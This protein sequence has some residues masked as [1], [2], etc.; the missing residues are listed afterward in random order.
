MAVEAP[1]FFILGGPGSGKGTN[2]D[3]LVRDFGMTHFSAGDLLR[4]EA[5][6][7]TPLGAK[8]TKILADGQI[9]PSEVTVELLKNAITSAKDAKGFLIDGFPRKFDQ[10]Q[11]F[12]EGIAKARRVLYFDCSE[13]T[14]EARLV[15]RGAAGSGRSDDDIETIRKRFRVNKEQCVPVVEKYKNEGRCDVISADDSKEAVYAIV[16]NLFIGYGCTPLEQ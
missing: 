15:A 12:E 7:D 5:S 11:M 4:A 3:N 13:A 9:V 14:M 8:I 16:K 10:A 6:K 1:V 2:C